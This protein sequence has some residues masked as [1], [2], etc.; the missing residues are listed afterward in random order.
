VATF[1]H[2]L[3]SLFCIGV[4]FVII[5]AFVIRAARKNRR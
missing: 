1:V 3:G 5:L 4:T 2:L